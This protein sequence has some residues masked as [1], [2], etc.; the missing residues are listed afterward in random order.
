MKIIKKILFWI[1]FI[2]SAGLSIFI[3]MTMP[4]RKKSNLNQRIKDTKEEVKANRENIQKFLK[5]HPKKKK[6]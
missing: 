5:L 4:K 1:M 6:K 2:I 3:Y